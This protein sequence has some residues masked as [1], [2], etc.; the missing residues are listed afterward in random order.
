MS[1]DKRPAHAADRAASPLGGKLP[2]VLIAVVVVIGL[3]LACATMCT[4]GGAAPDAA[5]PGQENSSQG[6]SDAGS[7][8]DADATAADEG[9]DSTGSAHATAQPGDQESPRA[10]GPAASDQA[11]FAVTDEML[12]DWSDK[13]CAL[14]AIYPANHVRAGGAGDEPKALTVEDWGTACLRYVDPNSEL[15]K[16]LRD[17][18]EAIATSLGF[19]D[20]A[21]YVSATDVL[22]ETAEG[23]TVEV[24]L[25]GTQMDW[26][27]T[28]SYTETLIVHF[29]ENAQVT[30]ID[31]L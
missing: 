19:Y 1:Q 17:N 15:G 21:S 18:P 13:A 24:T 3:A 11:G 10:G 2:L 22:L 25:E 30:G 7:A 29:N 14:L 4:R 27:H 28:S 20:A 16:T 9:D 26:D 6:T 8:D 5:K 31:M 23:I 12:A